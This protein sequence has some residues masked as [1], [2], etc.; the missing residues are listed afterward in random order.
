[1]VIESFRVNGFQLVDTQ[2]LSERQS[3]EVTA[4]IS[5]GLQLFPLEYQCE[6]IKRDPNGEFPIVRLGVF[7]NR[8]LLIGGLWFGCNLLEESSTKLDVRIFTRP[9][10]G[11]ILRHESKFWKGPIM[12]LLVNYFLRNQLEIREGGTL[13]IIGFDYIADSRSDLS[14]IS[15]RAAR[16]IRQ[17]GLTNWRPVVWLQSLGRE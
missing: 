4:A 3:N 13:Q 14:R 9:S 8:D 17:Q 2:D 7:D 12:T 15:N 10:I 11:P 5:F 6:A 16:R 1:M